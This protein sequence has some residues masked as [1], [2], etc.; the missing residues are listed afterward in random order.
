MDNNR[1]ITIT[2]VFYK[3]VELLMFHRYSA[4][5]HTTDN[6]FGFRSKHSTDMCVFALQQI[7][8]INVS[9]NSPVYI[10]YLDVSKAF[11]L[12]IIYHCFVNYQIY[13]FL[14]SLSD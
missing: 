2:T 9:M 5:L 12:S 6:Q 8:D 3:V 4:L 10:C 11:D 14:S 13:L 1:P 7:G